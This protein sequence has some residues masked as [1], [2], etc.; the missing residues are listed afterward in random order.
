MIEYLFSALFFIVPLIFYPK[1]SEVFEFNKIVV[2]YIFTTLIMAVWLIK[3]IQKKKIL[4]KHTILDIPF[5]LFLGSQLIS[6]I[7]SIDT[8]TSIF[9]YYSRFNGGFLSTLCYTLL[10]WAFVSNIKKKYI[11]HIILSILVS[12]VIVSIYGIFE[13]FGASFS[14]IFIRGK[15]NDSCWVQD[16]KSRVFAT[17]GQP[18]WLAAFLV[19]VMPMAL[20]NVITQKESKTKIIYTIISILFFACILFTK[21]RSGL[22][23]LGISYLIF[24]FFNIRKNFKLFIILNLIFLVI[25]A[26]FGTPITPSIN[27]LMHPKITQKV[28]TDTTEGGTESGIIRK[29][30]WKGAIDIF[31]HNPITGTGVE[32]FGYSYWQYRPVEHNTVSEWDFLYNKAHNE[33]LNIAA[34][35]GFLGLISYSILVSLSIFILRKNPALLAGYVSILITNFF[36]FSVVIISLL[37]FLM[38]GIEI[39]LKDG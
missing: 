8:R 20:S 37:F 22:L 31:K 26:I 16:I 17:L 39:I 24:W 9:G 11:K 7:I 29:I 3:M 21:S 27:D 36:G 14:C 38:P 15:F 23:A 6:T 2:V 32:T 10:Y 35:T 12:A 18:N 5:L 25:V 34:N 30:V 28:S 33:Y 13:H 1:T 4:F 19:A